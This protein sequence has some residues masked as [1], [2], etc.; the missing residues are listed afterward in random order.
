MRILC[1]RTWPTTPPAAVAMSPTRI[2]ISAVARNAHCAWTV[3]GSGPPGA[4]CAGSRPPRC[5]WRWP[6]C[7]P[8]RPGCGTHASSPDPAARR[9]AIS[10]RRRRGA[11]PPCRSARVCRTAGRRDG[12]AAW[13]AAARALSA[14]PSRTAAASGPRSAARTPRRISPGTVARSRRAFASSCELVGSGRGTHSWS[15]GAGGMGSGEES[16]ST[17]AM[18]TPEMPSTSA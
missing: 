12:A 14:A 10:G 2:G 7:G 6:G 8:S 15:G 16:N 9:Q 3:R 13:G 17:V 4:G 5:P 1:T 18:S 11:C